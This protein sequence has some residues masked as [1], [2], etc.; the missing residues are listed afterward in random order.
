MLLS[1]G[2][3]A[4]H[5][6]HVM[7]HESF[8]DQAT[9]EL[10]NELFVNIK[11][12]REERP[13][14]DSVYMQAVQALTGG[15]GWPMTVFLT[16]DGSPFYGGT[17]FPPAPRH[18]MPAFAQVLRAIAEAY[19]TQRD[20]VAS[21]GEQ[22]RSVMTG[23]VLAPG[24]PPGLE[25]LDLAAALLLEQHD[26]RD[27]GFGGAPKFPHPA[28]IDLLLR[29]RRHTGDRAALDAALFSLDRMARGGIHDQL[30]GGFHRYSV[31]ARWAVPHFEKML[32]DNAQLAPVYLHAY[33]LGAG[34]EARRV[35]EATLDWALREMRLDGGG[36]AS[37]QDADSEGEEGR[38]FVWT[39]AQLGEALGAEDGALAARLLGVTER[40]NV[41][42]GA[43]VLSLPRPLAAQ[44]SELRLE[45]PVLRERLD[46]LRARL[47]EV[48]RRRTP[49]ARDDKVLTS[50]NALMVG[51]LAE[52]GAALGRLDWVAAG[53]DCAVFL[54]GHLRSA[55]G[56]LLRTWRDGAAKI[57]AFL[58]DHAFLADALVRLHEATG[59]ERWV[60]E[61]RALVDT[62][63][64]RFHVPGEGWFD[65]A[66]DADPLTVRP[67]T[68]D[69]NPIPA[70]QST[71]AR[72]LLRLHALTGESDLVELAEAI[73]APLGAA[74]ARSPLALA[75]L[76]EAVELLVR[77]V[78][79]VAVVGEPDDP[80]T[81]RLLGVV[82]E[83]FHPEA[84]LA[85]GGGAVPLLR[86]RPALGG[87][88]TAYVCSGFSCQAPVVEP[89]RLRAQLAVTGA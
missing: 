69:D 16:P 15:G 58:E 3:S 80:G 13:D 4:C 51:A 61:A 27:G 2:Y 56:T 63:V 77:P 45:E 35:V 19:R 20:V 83:G 8:E 31:D 28:A 21:T 67:R 64:Q 73:V 74:V 71:M 17:Y 75:S 11:V 39:P 38:Y 24:E 85:W 37:S 88:P 65:T 84:V 62:A 7:A 5:W 66:A 14:V 70:G 82:R 57:P 68:I 22:L 79:E 33:Q 86:D 23:P 47:L 87:R 59:E 52:C 44:A 46:G 30:A 48:R 89:D 72:A 54:L 43:S 34:D 42:G 49:P 41:E 29:R 6:C 32:Y 55:D 78:R 9:A 81:Q 76:A 1:V 18:G 50:W 40:G 60:H 12:D 36:F 25:Q 10:M 26:P 53:R